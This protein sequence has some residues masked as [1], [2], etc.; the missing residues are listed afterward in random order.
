[1]ADLRI[2]VK[3]YTI[4]PLQ[5]ITFFLSTLNIMLTAIMRLFDYRKLNAE[6]IR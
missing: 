2:N 4:I 6:L 3:I 1:M 5:S